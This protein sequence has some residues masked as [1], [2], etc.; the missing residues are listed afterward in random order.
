MSGNTD[1][2]AVAES[3]CGSEK[4]RAAAAAPPPPWPPFSTTRRR[5][6]TDGNIARLTELN[7]ARKNH[8]FTHAT[9]WKSITKVTLF[10]NEGQTL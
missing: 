8:L 2:I 10:S 7:F 4:M 6:C 1:N 9:F 3:A 5:R